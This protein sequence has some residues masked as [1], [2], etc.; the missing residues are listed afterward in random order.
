MADAEVG[1]SWAYLPDLGKAFEKVAW[2]R[3][4]LA[5]YEN[6]H[7]AGHFL[8]HGELTA[9][10]VET[11]PVPLKV[12]PMAW[13][14]LRMLGVM[15]PLLREVIKM[16]YLWQNTMELRDKR[17]DAILGPDFGTPVKEAVAAT[18]APFFAKARMAA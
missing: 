16:R 6:F 18:V 1:H 12:V 9:A 2:H 15:V 13:G 17:L 3:K 14:T 11:A 5:Q 7:F 10:I 8:T 4:E